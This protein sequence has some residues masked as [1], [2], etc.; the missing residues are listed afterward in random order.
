M[1]SLASLKLH[2]KFL[3]IQNQSLSWIKSQLLPGNTLA[4]P[5]QVKFKLQQTNIKLRNSKFNNAKE[6]ID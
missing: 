3:K 5:I 2:S 4:Q 1:K 6:D